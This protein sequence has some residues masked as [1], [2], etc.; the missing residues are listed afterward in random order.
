MM[1]HGYVPSIRG[2]GRAVKI[3]ST[4]VGNYNLDR[5]TAQGYLSRTPG[6]ARAFALTGLARALVE[7]HYVTDV[8]ELREEIRLL[9]CENEQLRRDYKSQNAT[10]ERELNLS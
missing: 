2:I 5:L 9:R 8:R 3:S 1:D 10:L 4:S 7:K 6:K